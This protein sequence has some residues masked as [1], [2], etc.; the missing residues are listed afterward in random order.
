MEKEPKVVQLTIFYARQV[1]VFD[2]FPADKV[3]EI[4]SPK[5]KGD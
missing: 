1:V 4:N 5:K 2:N 3:E